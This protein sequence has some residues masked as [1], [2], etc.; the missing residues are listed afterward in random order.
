MRYKRFDYCLDR[1]TIN[2][3]YYRINDT[4]LYSERSEILKWNNQR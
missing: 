2:Y 4:A 1:C 3:L